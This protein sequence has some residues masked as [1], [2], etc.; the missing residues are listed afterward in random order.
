VVHVQLERI[1]SRPR[2][3]DGEVPNAFR[4]TATIMRG[5]TRDDINT[6]LHALGM[7]GLQASLAAAGIPPSGQVAMVWNPQ[8][9]GAPN[10]AGNQ[11]HAYWPGGGYVDYVADDLYSQNFRAYWK[12]MQPLYNYGKPFILGECCAVGDGRSDLRHQR[13]QLGED[14]PPHRGDRL[15]LP[16]EHLRPEP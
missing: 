14:P 15:P 16:L 11:P 10:V 3:L 2:L 8:G 7:H 4:R 5:G 12:G 9:Q 1:A 13:L 6:R